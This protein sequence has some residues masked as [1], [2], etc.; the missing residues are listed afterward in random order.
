MKLIPEFH[1]IDLMLACIG[2][3]FTM[4]PTRAALAVEWVKPKQV[5]PMHFGTYPLLAGSPTQFKE[6]L[7]RRGLGARMIEMKPG[8][9]RRF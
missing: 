5:M 8:E 4:D 9:T 3:H 2:G 6:A 1:Q 7:D